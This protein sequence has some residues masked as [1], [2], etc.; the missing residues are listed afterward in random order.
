MLLGI[1]EATIQ[2]LRYDIV[3]FLYERCSYNAMK[4]DGK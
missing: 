3:W 4:K 1:S 2:D